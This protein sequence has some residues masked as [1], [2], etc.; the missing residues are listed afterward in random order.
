MKASYERSRVSNLTIAH[1]ESFI[2][3]ES[4]HCN[5]WTFLYGFIIIELNE[6]LIKNSFRI[7]HE[8]YRKR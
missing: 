2:Y 8:V 3:V 4:I 1:G 6:M 5:V 7:V